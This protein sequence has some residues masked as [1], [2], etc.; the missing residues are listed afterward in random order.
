MVKIEKK[1]HFD[2]DHKEKKGMTC[3]ATENINDHNNVTESEIL[4]AA[5]AYEIIHPKPTE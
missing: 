5:E 1:N 3:A 4:I 2:S